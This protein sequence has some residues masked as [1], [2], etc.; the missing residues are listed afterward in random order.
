M[1][2]MELNK[3]KRAFDEELID[4]NNGINFYSNNFRETP[5]YAK[6]S[7]IITVFNAGLFSL[8]LKTLMEKAF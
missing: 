2:R 6:Y 7:D 3:Q 8:T 4:F 5:V 1:K